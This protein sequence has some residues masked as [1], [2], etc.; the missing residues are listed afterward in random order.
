MVASKKKDGD[1]PAAVMPAESSPLA[2]Y[3]AAVLPVYLEQLGWQ[4]RAVP[5][6][7]RSD[8]RT[9]LPESVSRRLAALAGEGG[10]P[11]LVSCTAPTSEEPGRLST[12]VYDPETGTRRALEQMAFSLPDDYSF[13]KE[14]HHTG[15]EGLQQNWFRLLKEMYPPGA[16][17]GDLALRVRRAEVRYFFIHGRWSACAERLNH[18]NGKTA[19]MDFLRRVMAL[20]L[21]GKAEEADDLLTAAIESNPDTGR[22]YLLQAWC[23]RGEDPEKALKLIDKGK[24]TNVKK[25]GY[26]QFARALMA[27]ESKDYEAAEKA[28]TAAS[29]ALKEKDFVQLKAARFYWD[30]A[31]LEKAITYYRRALKTGGDTASI[32]A[33][34]GSALAMAGEVE[35]A[36]DALQAAA[37]LNPWRPNVAKRRSA[38][39]ERRGQYSKAI[40][41]LRRA[42][43]ANSQNPDF[44]SAYGDAAAHRWLL[45]EAA[46]AYRKALEAEPNFL[47]AKARLA[48]V[49]ARRNQYDKAREILKPLVEN[50]GSYVP[51]AVALGLVLTA[52]GRTEDAA[53]VLSDVAADSD[54]EV[55]RRMALCKVYLQAGDHAQAVRHAQ[56]AVSMSKSPATYAMLSR[57]FLAGDELSKAGA[58]AQGAMEQNPYSARAHLALAR[59]QAARDETK[60]R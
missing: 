30:R 27:L 26:Y 36:I 37:S 47:Y 58:A 52:E 16:G 18:A 9:G 28:L 50:D 19:D 7:K 4:S 12:A 5:W 44:L 21:A 23:I 49:L 42:S 34:L 13:L 2:G 54:A 8:V 10:A 11:V 40:E 1:G 38:L 45:D 33:E 24:F 31:E 29:D 32:W 53:E 22:L 39:F 17:N 35:K 57:A 48:R 43:K 56:T 15:L 14:D 41:G 59:V 60:R 51:A 25:E 46:E 55:A 6:E 20:Q 3:G